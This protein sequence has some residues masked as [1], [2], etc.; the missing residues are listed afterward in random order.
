MFIT[1]H[2]STG[3]FGT[4]HVAWG[5][6]PPYTS[7]AAGIEGSA[8]YRWQCWRAGPQ[9]M[10]HVVTTAHHPRSANRAVA[11]PDQFAD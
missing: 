8:M 9:G 6:H 10:R 11:R 2:T 5:T 3:D 1:T 7:R 4:M